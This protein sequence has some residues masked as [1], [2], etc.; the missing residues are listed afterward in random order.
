MLSYVDGNSTE[1]DAC[2]AFS[3]KYRNNSCLDE[4][5]AFTMEDSHS[6]HI[7]VSVGQKNSWGDFLE[8]VIQC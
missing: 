3:V 7:T 6:L 4:S 5:Q 1:T 8:K 2:S